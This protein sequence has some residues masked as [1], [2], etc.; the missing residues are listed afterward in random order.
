MADWFDIPSDPGEYRL[1]DVSEREYTFVS[2]G[3]EGQEMLQVRDVANPDEVEDVVVHSSR[4]HA[5]GWL[6]A[7]TAQIKTDREARTAADDTARKAANKREFDRREA[8]RTIR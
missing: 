1:P 5:E 8:A 4:A 3:H 7:Q 6:A 2:F